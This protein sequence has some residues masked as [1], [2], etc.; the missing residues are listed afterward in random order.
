MKKYLEKILNQEP[1]S[2][3]SFLKQC[4]KNNISDQKNRTIFSI[5]SNGKKNQYLLTIKNKQL[6]EDTFSNFLIKHE[7]KKVEAALRGNSKKA[8]SS[9]SLMIWKENSNGVNSIAIE[10]NNQDYVLNI[11]KKKKLIIIENLNNFLNIKSN[12]PELDLKEYNFVWGN[13]NNIT[14]KNFISFLNEYEEVI[15]FFD[16]DLGGFKMFKSLYNQLNTKIEFYFNDFMKEKIITHGKTITID[17]YN[18]TMKFYK[19]V[20]ALNDVLLFINKHQKFAE[21]EIF[22]QYEKGNNQ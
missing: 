20:P 9:R 10:F 3:S 6:F 1:I 14:D 17:Q 12:F 11:D 8:K 15:C 7:D 13:G 2:Y 16:I 19:D 4:E 5:S 22:Q 18:T 21:Q